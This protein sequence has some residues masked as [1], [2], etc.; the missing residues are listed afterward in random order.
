[1]K[2]NV[3]NID[4]I[5][6]NTT[7]ICII[8]TGDQVHERRLSSS[9]PPYDPQHLTFFYMKAYIFQHRIIHIVSKCHMLEQN[10]A[11]WLLH[12]HRMFNLLNIGHRI[13]DLK[14]PLRRVNAVRPHMKHPGK[15]THRPVQL[16]HISYKRNEDA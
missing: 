6:I 15:E 11:L 10:I 16:S 1:M 13:H 7:F 14:H 8:Q 2:S 5:H 4:T 3:F 9:R 12:A